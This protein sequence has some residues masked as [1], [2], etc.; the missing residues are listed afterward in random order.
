MLIPQTLIAA[1][2]AEYPPFAELSS[3][4]QLRIAQM[5]WLWTSASQRHRQHPDAIAFTN[6]QIKKLWGNAKTMREVI[7]GDYFCVFKADN[8]SL[9]KNYCNAFWPL[10]Y[11]G[12]AL[13]KC[14]LDPLP[15][16]FI[17]GNGFQFKKIRN[18]IRSRAAPEGAGQKHSVWKGIRC[19]SFVP[20]NHDALLSFIRGKDLLEILS[21][22]RLLRIS[23]NEHCPGFIPVCYEQ[24]SSGRIFEILTGFQNTPREVRNAALEGSWDYDISNCHFSILGQWGE[25]A[26]IATHAIDDYLVNKKTIRN[27][28]AAQCK[29]EVA[30][31]KESLIALLY[32]ASQSYKP[33]FSSVSRSMGE[34]AT[35][36]FMKDPFIKLLNADI[37]R[38]RR[39]IVGSLRR[40]GGGVG[41]VLGVFTPAVEDRKKKSDA[42][43]LCHALQGIEAQALRAVLKHYGD[44]ILLPMHDGWV[45][46]TRLEVGNLERLIFE[47]TGYRLSVE[48]KRL[49]KSSDSECPQI[50]SQV[51]KNGEIIN[52]DQILEKF[53]GIFCTANR[54]LV[55]A[56]SLLLSCRPDWNRPESVRA[57]RRMVKELIKKEQAL[58]ATGCMKSPMVIPTAFTIDAFDVFFLNFSQG[59]KNENV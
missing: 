57:K 24:K 22:L 2:K 41:N 9:D 40:H 43:L 8:L 28:L 17:D 15:I 7:G 48:E 59:I 12:R 39:P 20:I 23:N 52:A 49:Q 56:S 35:T 42:Q 4:N 37:R 47:A 1:I 6:R 51:E 44:E 53:S 25:K 32:G 45:S 55:P 54:H 21:V 50:Q 10:D 14:L 19:P 58:A 46:R 30:L 29:V 18:A 13:L 5:L 38:V 27:R 16:D 36:I 11:M 33:E 26:G 3:I 34:A 31:I